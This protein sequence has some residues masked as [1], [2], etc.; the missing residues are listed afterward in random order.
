MTFIRVRHVASLRDDRGLGRQLTSS[1][2]SWV[3]LAKT[4][5]EHNASTFAQIATIRL[6][7][8]ATRIDQAMAAR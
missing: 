3:R 2:P 7:L 4:Q 1:C 6:R 5:P 8:R